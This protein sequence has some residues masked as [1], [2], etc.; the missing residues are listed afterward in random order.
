MFHHGDTA[1]INN[2]QMGAAFGSANNFIADYGMRFSRVGTGDQDAV[3]I[4]N[5]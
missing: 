1:R 2:D 3:R 4:T 5:F